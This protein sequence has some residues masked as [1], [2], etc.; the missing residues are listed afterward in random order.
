VKFNKSTGRNQECGSV[1]KPNGK[2]FEPM[3]T[4]EILVPMF[5]LE[6]KILNLSI[7]GPE[8]I[9]MDVQGNELPA[10]HGL[11]LFCDR[12][13]MIWT[14]VAYQAYYEGQMLAPEFDHAMQQLGF[15]KIFEAPG[16][17]GWF[18]DAC[19]QRK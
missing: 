13:Q 17:P 9:W 18:G 15:Q 16:I 10:L 14:E 3:P 6:T 12:P 5:R 19:Y 7:P 1:L 11:G 2:Y 8:L 4:A